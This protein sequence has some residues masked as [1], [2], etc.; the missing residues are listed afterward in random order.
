[1]K[2]QLHL[3]AADLGR[4]IL[5]LKFL[6]SALAIAFFLFLSSYSY[7]HWDENGNS[8]DDVVTILEMAFSA[9]TNAV[10][11]GTIALLPFATSYAEDM[12]ENSASF[13][14]IRSGATPYGV[15]KYIVSI[16]SGFLV[17]ACGILLYALFLS[18]HLP[19]F[20][21]IYS[22]GADTGFEIFLYE[23]KP[24]LYLL[25]FAAA[26]GLSAAFC[27]GACVWISSIFPNRF[28]ALAGPAL[29]YLLLVRFDRGILLLPLQYSTWNLVERTHGMGSAL[30]TLGYKLLYISVFLIPMGIHALGNIKRRFRNA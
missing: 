3:F 29:L 15:C 28:A 20:L 24:L 17:M 9:F 27:C 23:G 30:P 1:M 6:F 11:A 16:L 25:C 10:P 8:L 26:H 22:S 19:F 21:G 2:K 7:I 5:S 18:S 14:V 4:A 13:L 12:A